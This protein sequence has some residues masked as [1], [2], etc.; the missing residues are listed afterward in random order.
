[1]NHEEHSTD[2]AARARDLLRDCGVDAEAMSEQEIT[3]R[4]T[5]IADAATKYANEMRGGFSATFDEHIESEFTHE[6]VDE[7]MATMVDDPWLVLAPVLTGGVGW[8]EVETYYREDFIGKWPK[9]LAITPI[10]RTIG[11]RQVVEE[12]VADFTHDI[13]MPAILPGIAATGKK[14]SL[15]FVVIMG[16]N[17]DT[18]KV[19]HEHVYWDQG[20]FLLQVGLIDESLPVFGPEQ[21]RKLLDKHALPSNPLNKP[22]WPER[23]PTGDDR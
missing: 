17:P 3:R 4:A 12:M 16:F 18:G 21:G 20:C 6:S 11:D 1:M 2:V 15:P 10:S 9:D 7:T 23:S 19:T 22:L 14:V 13:E 8:D 5:A